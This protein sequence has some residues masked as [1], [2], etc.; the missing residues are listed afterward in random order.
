MLYKLF[1]GL[2]KVFKTQNNWFSIIDN[3]YLIL[4]FISYY[5]S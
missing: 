3:I 1:R 5:S 4:E 2:A